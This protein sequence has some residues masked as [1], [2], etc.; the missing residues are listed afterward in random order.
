MP[1]VP[2]IP[3]MD[4][5]ISLAP[6]WYRSWHFYGVKLR[7]RLHLLVITANVL[8]GKW[9]A[10]CSDSES[11]WF[12]LC[13]IFTKFGLDQKNRLLLLYLDRKWR[14]LTF[15]PWVQSRLRDLVGDDISCWPFITDSR[16][17]HCRYSISISVVKCS[18][19]L[20][21][22]VPPVQIFTAQNRLLHPSRIF[23]RTLRIPFVRKK[24]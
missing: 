3:G 20:H 4:F 7:C 2:T 9:S 19:E 1:N 8:L 12:L 6:E 16:F 10:H 14:I 23:P 21:S 13:L 17:Q 22:L 11:S 24:L 18:P 5:P 15:Q